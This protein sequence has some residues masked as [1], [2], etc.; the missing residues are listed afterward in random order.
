MT[1]PVALQSGQ[2]R[3]TLSQSGE[4]GGDLGRPDLIRWAF[5]KRCSPADLEA[6]TQPCCEEGPC[7][8][9]VRAPQELPATLAGS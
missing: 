6:S 9:E 8:K 1:V 5:K 7:G 3:D 4:K 2:Q